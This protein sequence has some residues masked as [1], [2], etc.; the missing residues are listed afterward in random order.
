MAV[1]HGRTQGTTIEVTLWRELADKFYAFLEEGRVGWPS[2]PGFLLQAMLTLWWALTCV[3]PRQVYYFKRGSV[4]LAN[5]NYQNA[6]NDYIIHME[7]GWDPARKRTGSQASDGCIVLLT[8][9]VC[10]ARSDIEACT[11]CD[12]GNMCARLN[13]VGLEHLARYAGK[14]MLVDVLGLVTSV[15][16]FLSPQWSPSQHC[17]LPCM[18]DARPCVYNDVI[19]AGRCPWQ[20]QAHP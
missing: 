17:I 1:C 4:K 14:K 20:R 18:Q 12:G 19:S 8:C 15:S 6:R 13:Y 7:N 16:P 5:R 10:T 9:D 2:S 3:A 11:D